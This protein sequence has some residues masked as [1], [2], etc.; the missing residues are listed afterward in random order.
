MNKI[1]IVNYAK[2]KWICACN[3][4]L[5]RFWKDNNVFIWHLEKMQSE[6]KSVVHLPKG[7]RP[8]SYSS[9]VVKTIGNS[10][11]FEKIMSK[12]KKLNRLLS[13]DE[14]DKYNKISTRDR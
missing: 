8:V 1:D 10:T 12:M 13:K 14:I 11:D 2:K 3:H 4:F 9:S 6:I 5:N 7:V